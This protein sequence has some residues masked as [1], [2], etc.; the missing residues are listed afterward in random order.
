MVRQ[1]FLHVLR[2]S[3]PQ[4]I[5]HR[6]STASSPRLCLRTIAM[7]L[8]Q[9]APSE[10]KNFPIWHQKVPKALQLPKCP[11]LKDILGEL[12][13]IKGTCPADLAWKLLFTSF[14]FFGFVRVGFWQN[15]FFADFYFWAAGFFRGFCRRMFSPHFCG[16]KC[17]EKSSRKIP[18][19]ILKMLY[20]KIPDTFLQRG[21]AKVCGSQGLYNRSRLCPKESGLSR[22]RSWEVGGSES[23]EFHHEVQRQGGGQE[24]GRMRNSEG[25]EWALVLRKP[26]QATEPFRARN[27]KRVENESKKE[28]PGPS[29]PRGPKSPKESKK[30]CEPFSPLQ[31][32]KTPETQICPKF[33]PAI[34]LGGSSQGDWNL[35]KFVKI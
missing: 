8:W 34:V 20:N 15:G 25:R 31:P 2:I 10:A 28:S 27:P 1:I 12:K 22:P 7:P 29:G 35:E 26:P 23:R 4:K 30:S 32:S 19:K 3:H 13:E 24:A 21:W 6:P 18:D 14:S 5:C 16:E 33:V 9:L 11:L 17:P